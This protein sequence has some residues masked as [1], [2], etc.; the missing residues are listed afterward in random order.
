MSDPSDPSVSSSSAAASSASI[1]RKIE[2]LGTSLT[3]PTVRKALGVLEGEH[4]SQQRFGN[5]DV[6]DIRRY[7]A[8][9]E[10]KL[11]DWKTS[12]R[13]SMAVWRCRAAAPPA[14]TPMTW[15]PMR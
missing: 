15:L 7:I 12:A 14:N 4:S 1:R 11:I 9:D 13:C 10:A 3:L 5:D 6:M 2:E 8:G